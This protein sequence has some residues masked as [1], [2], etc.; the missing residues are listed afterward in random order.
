MFWSCKITKTF[1]EKCLF[2]YSLEMLGFDVWFSTY[3]AGTL[4]L[5]YGSSHVQNSTYFSHLF[6][7]PTGH[8]SWLPWKKFVEGQSQTDIILSPP[9]YWWFSS[10]TTGSGWPGSTAVISKHCTAPWVQKI[11][12]WGKHCRVC[13]R[14]WH[15]SW[16]EKLQQPHSSHPFLFFVKP[17]FMNGRQSN[18]TPAVEECRSDKVWLLQPLATVTGY[19]EDGDVHLLPLSKGSSLQWDYSILCQLLS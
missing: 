1:F 18:P 12:L 2:Q 13:V 17:N 16:G 3:K 14:G 7:C 10:C 11:V 6:S 15:L 4:Q 8:K 5:S 19:S 9:N